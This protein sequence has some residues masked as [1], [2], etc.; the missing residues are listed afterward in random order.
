MGFVDFDKPMKF[1]RG[2]ARRQARMVKMILI[3]T[4]N[5]ICTA[6]DFFTPSKSCS[7]ILLA[8]TTEKPA[9]QPNAN[10]RTINIILPVLLIP[11]TWFASRYLP[12]IAAS[13]I[14]YICCK[15]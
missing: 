4:D 1:S 15:N 13:A 6:N 11:A 5:L 2:L 7:P 9:V 12:H 10:C 14:V 8:V 3:I